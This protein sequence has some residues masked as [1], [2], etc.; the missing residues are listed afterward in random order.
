MS[1]PSHRMIRL[2]LRAWRLSPR[3]RGCL[4][5]CWWCLRGASNITCEEAGVV[6]SK[7]ATFPS[8]W[9]CDSKCS[10]FIWIFAIPFGS[11]HTQP[12]PGKNPTW[13]VL[14]FPPCEL[15]IIVSSL[16][17]FFLFVFSV[18]TEATKK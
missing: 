16:N 3:G 15:T 7:E 17:P 9:M 6:T 11:S 5:V 12:Y 8:L 18:G 4:C 13:F 14:D 2:C 1:E 10:F